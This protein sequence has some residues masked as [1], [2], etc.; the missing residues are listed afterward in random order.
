M[1]KKPYLVA[2]EKEGVRNAYVALSVSTVACYKEIAQ[3]EEELGEKLTIL[4]IKDWTIQK[5][6]EEIECFLNEK[7]LLKTNNE[8]KEGNK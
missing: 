3:T 6:L 5:V 4:P 8:T 1:V 2:V 7:P